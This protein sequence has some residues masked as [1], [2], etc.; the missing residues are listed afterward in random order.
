MIMIEE[1]KDLLRR[2][3]LA[4]DKILSKVEAFLEKSEKVSSEVLMDLSD[5][6]KDMAK[7]EKC[8]VSSYNMLHEHKENVEM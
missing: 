1:H 4:K 8:I 7:A 3:D 5:I 6:V 2:M